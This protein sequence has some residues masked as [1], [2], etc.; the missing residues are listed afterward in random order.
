[1]KKPEDM[2][3]HEIKDEIEILVA[4]QAEDHGREY[5]LR[6]R[7]AL[8]ACPYKIGDVLV[9]RRG[10]RARVDSIGIPSWRHNQ[11]SISGVYLKADGTPW[12][13]PGRDNNR[14]RSCG[15]DIQE[16]WSRPT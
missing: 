16:D 5:Q 3:P 8:D 4:R 2:T 15:F 12:K 6:L 9:N 10:E 11:F 7:L 1:M 14:P 13:N